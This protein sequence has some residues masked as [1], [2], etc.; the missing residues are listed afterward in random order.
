MAEL[1]GIPAISSVRPS[2]TGLRSLRL[3]EIG[4]AVAEVKLRGRDKL[5]WLFTFTAAVFNIWRIAKLQA[6]AC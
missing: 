4:R 6:A 2:V 5:W 3:D 1:P